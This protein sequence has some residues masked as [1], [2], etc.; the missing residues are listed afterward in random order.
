MRTMMSTQDSDDGK[1][2]RLAASGGKAFLRVTGEAAVLV[3]NCETQT[4]IGLKALFRTMFEHADD[5]LFDMVDQGAA[6]TSQEEYVDGMRDIRLKRETM[7]E[8]FSQEM[9]VAFSAFVN[10]REYDLGVGAVSSAGSEPSL[11]LV[12]NDELEESL[13][14]DTMASKAQERYAEAL[15]RLAERFAH[16]RGDAELDEEDLPFSPRIIVNALLRASATLKVALK[17]RL[18][19]YKLFDRHVLTGLADL[20]D[21]LDDRLTDAGVPAGSKPKPV[22][23][24]P[25]S[26]SPQG[27]QSLGEGEEEAGGGEAAGAE[28][29]YAPPGAVVAEP[30]I[31][32]QEAQKLFD[33]LR[34]L[35]GMGGAPAAG[36]GYAPPAAGGGYAP[37]SKPLVQALSNLQGNVPE[38]TR[39]GGGQPVAGSVINPM[40]ME[41]IARTEEVTGR[42]V[43][44]QGDEDIIDVVGMLFDFILSDRNLSSQVKVVLAR[45]QIPLVKVAILDKSFF[46]KK[47]HPARRLLNELAQAGIGLGDNAARQDAVKAEIERVVDRVLNNFEENVGIFDELLDEF[48]GFVTGL[49]QRSQAVEERQA[50]TL[51][52]RERLELG[53]TQVE[54]DVAL[55]IERRALPPGLRTFLDEK[56]R[57]HLLITYLKVGAGGSEY[58]DGLHLMDKLIWTMEPKHT[59]SERQEV[60]N[61]LRPLLTSLRDAL[62]ET[63]MDPDVHKE[64]FFKQ[65]QDYQ[66]QA[67]RGQDPA[68]EERSARAARGE[69]DEP[70]PQGMG[71]A[72]GAEFEIPDEVLTEVGHAEEDADADE[73]AQQAKDIPE[74][75]WLEYTQPDAEKQRVKLSWRSPMTAR[76]L[77][78]N[79]RGLKELEL[80]AAE[81]ADHLRRGELAPLTGTPLVDRALGALVKGIKKGLPHR[82]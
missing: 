16:V 73:Y 22:V 33:A 38:I 4:L 81:F 13:A 26:D 14:L 47:Q 28:T 44:Q 19:F 56:W 77:F 75:T 43:L 32:P 51:E 18:I 20:Y 80:S 25:Q 79:S 48:R 71:A 3:S 39:G 70:L 21:Q 62:I 9:R 46:T 29:A 61:S 11:S 7:E 63:F 1:V 59:P 78:V 45:L 49:N 34:R 74:G 52:G 27:P 37:R 24:R 53:K 35:L 10:G 8:T 6:G 40:V 5:L 72:E 41:Q 60:V 76:C 69:V 12:G 50:K 2:V 58:K 67:L 82:S 66:F 57:H 36:G 64:P 68:H 65:L 55:R 31:D 17:V 42:Q 54:R 30:I 15:A 23:R